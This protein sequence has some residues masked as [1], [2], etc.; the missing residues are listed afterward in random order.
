MRSS[1]YFL[2]LS[3]VLNSFVIL[4]QISHHF[5]SLSSSPSSYSSRYA[6]IAADAAA[7]RS[8]LVFKHDEDKVSRN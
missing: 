1:S 7:A 3:R 2:L 8:I 6:L 5:F 4:E